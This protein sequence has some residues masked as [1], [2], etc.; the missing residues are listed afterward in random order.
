MTAFYTDV[1]GTRHTLAAPD[2]RIACLVPSITE[3]LCD[4]GLGPQLVART[5]FCIHPREGLRAVPKVGGTKDVDLA[6]LATLTPTHAVVNIDENTRETAEALR[7]FVPNVIVTH[8]MGPEDN[9]GLY[10]LLGGI[11]GRETEAA[12]LCAKLAT[13]MGSIAGLEGRRL[14]RVLYL[15]WRDPWMTV[16]RDTYISRTLA[17]FHWLTEPANAESRYPVIALPEAAVGVD[18]ILLS[19]E[20]YPFRARHIEEIRSLCPGVPVRIIDGEMTSWYGSRAI[21]G[22]RYLERFTRGE[23]VYEPE[24]PLDFV[25]GAGDSGISS[26]GQGGVVYVRGEPVVLPPRRRGPAGGTGGMRP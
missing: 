25:A 6:E 2:A 19:S 1:M 16:S 12:A 15:I 26:P 18:E 8:P 20:P 4:L 7:A 9:F 24:P 21:E 11:F 14:R 3:L 22:L 5:G 17:R 23:A 10:R 13:V